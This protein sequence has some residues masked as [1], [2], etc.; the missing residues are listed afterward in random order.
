ML[1]CYMLA[2]Y[3]I[4]RTIIGF[5]HNCIYRLHLFISFLCKCVIDNAID[6][7]CNT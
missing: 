5:A 4:Q 6:S 7:F 3:I 2:T 1:N